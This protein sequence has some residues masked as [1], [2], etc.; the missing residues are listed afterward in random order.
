M[1]RADLD[2]AGVVTRVASPIFVGRRDQLED[3]RDALDRAVSGRPTFLV[4][5]G[6]AGVGKTRF[7][8]EVARRAEADG[9]RALVG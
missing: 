1:M 2:N 5:A 6:D 3:V 8:D 4:V 9:W 7:V